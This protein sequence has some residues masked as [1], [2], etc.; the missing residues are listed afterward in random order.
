MLCVMKLKTLA[1]TR[2][3]HML[4][5]HWLIG[6]WRQ[7]WLVM[8]SARKHC[9]YL[10]SSFTVLTR[11]NSC[12][13]TKRLSILPTENILSA[14]TD[15]HSKYYSLNRVHRLVF[16]WGRKRPGSFLLHGIQNISGIHP[17]LTFLLCADPL[18]HIQPF[19]SPLHAERFWGPLS[20][21][22]PYSTV[23][24]WRWIWDP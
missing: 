8:A 11:H 5:V 10:F 7:L 3:H 4:T 9:R 1:S 2:R 16:V 15:C 14:S 22:P 12:Y 24:R 20:T 6:F 21:T 17:T 19:H 23:S 18:G 13:N